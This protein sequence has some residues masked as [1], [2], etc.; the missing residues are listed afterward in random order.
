M[1]PWK[2]SEARRQNRL[3]EFVRPHV[4]P[5]EHIIAILSRVYERVTSWGWSGVVALV[6]TR[7]RLF[8]VRPANMILL[9]ST[10]ILV[11]Y[12]RDGVTAEWTPDARIASAGQWGTYRFGKLRLADSLGAKELW[13]GRRWRQDHATRIALLL[14]HAGEL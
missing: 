7:Q 5:D 6:V 10:K 1:W 3:A 14:K 12:P 8:V 9:R 11:T 13:V 4:D 2:R